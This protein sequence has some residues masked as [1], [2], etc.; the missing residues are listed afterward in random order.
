MATIY[1]EFRDM[2]VSLSIHSGVDVHLSR[3]ELSYGVETEEYWNN[4][5]ILGYSKVFNGYSRNNST[6]NGWLVEIKDGEE[7]TEEMKGKDWSNWEDKVKSAWV[8]NGDFT[9]G[10]LVQYMDRNE[11]GDSKL[12]MQSYYHG[13]N[14]EQSVKKGRIYRI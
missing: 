12:G 8:F 14:G 3:K 1:E 5:N 7:I 10:F 6:I 4:N 13:K 9:S 11:S 2:M